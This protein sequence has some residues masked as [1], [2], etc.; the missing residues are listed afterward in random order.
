[1]PS[2]L[3]RIDAGLIPATRKLTTLCDVLYQTRREGFSETQ[4]EDIALIR[5]AA[6]GFQQYIN[7]HS[8]TWYAL[9]KSSLQI[10]RHDLKNRL[11]IVSGYASL[12]KRELDA[13]I[14]PAMLITLGG[15]V[16]TCQQLISQINELR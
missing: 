1:M 6:R 11:N 2:T 13:G 8:P 3:Q 10:L 7:E 4:Q 14:S 9:E 12:L 5:D 15:I 16:A